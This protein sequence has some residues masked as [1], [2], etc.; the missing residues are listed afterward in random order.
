MVA[1]GIKVTNWIYIIL[2]FLKHYA[3]FRNLQHCRWYLRYILT[4]SYCLL[5]LKQTQP[6]NGTM[7]YFNKP[8]GL[9][10]L[11]AFSSEFIFVEWGGWGR[12]FFDGGRGG[13]EA[14]HSTLDLQTTWKKI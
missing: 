11:K 8:M 1:I 3:F 2:W 4:I 5:N 7:N 14:C 13:T 10:F 9:K 12:V 6:F